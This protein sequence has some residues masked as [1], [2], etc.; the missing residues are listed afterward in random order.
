MMA[1][2]IIS[3]IETVSI[4]STSYYRVNSIDTPVQDLNDTL[5][6]VRVVIY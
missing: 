1:Y 4:I 5:K 2:S 6:E 3:T